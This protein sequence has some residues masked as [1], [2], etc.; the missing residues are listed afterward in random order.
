LILQRDWIAEEEPGE[1]VDRSDERIAELRLDF[2]S[3]SRRTDATIPSFLSPAAPP[4]DSTSS[5]GLPI[6]KERAIAVEETGVLLAPLH[7]EIEFKAQK[8]NRSIGHSLSDDGD[9]SDKHP[10]L[11]QKAVVLAASDQRRD[12]CEARRELIDDRDEFDRLEVDTRRFAVRAA[13]CRQL[14]I[15]VFEE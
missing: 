10:C 15:E 7:V 3:R 8:F 12:G 9:G 6:G 14:S 13:L 1:Y 5:V 2:L 4:T 11:D